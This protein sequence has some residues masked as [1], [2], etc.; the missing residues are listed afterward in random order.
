MAEHPR[1][2]EEAK[3][4]VIVHFPGWESISITKPN[5]AEGGFLPFYRRDDAE[6]RLAQ[7]M[8]RRNLAVVVCNLTYTQ[9]QQAEQ[10]MAWNSIF[11]KLGFHRVVFLHAGPTR[12]VNG[13]VVVKDVQLDSP[14][15]TGS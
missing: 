10:Q 1:F 3:A 9:D 12:G 15:Q 4:D 11:A 5:T 7:L 2:H 8:T 14:G 13:L 6:R